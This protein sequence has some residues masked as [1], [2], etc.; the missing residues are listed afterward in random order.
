[1][2]IFKTDFKAHTATLSTFV[3]LCV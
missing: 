2:Q 1:M 3:W